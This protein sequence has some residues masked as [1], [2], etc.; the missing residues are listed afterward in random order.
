[1]S[2]PL[3]NSQRPTPC[4]LSVNFQWPVPARSHHFGRWVNHIDWRFV[5]ICS[6]KDPQTYMLRTKQMKRS[7]GIFTVVIT[8]I[9][10]GVGW[11]WFAQAFNKQPTKGHTS[12]ETAPSHSW[13]DSACLLP[14]P[15]YTLYIWKTLKPIPMNVE[16]TRETPINWKTITAITGEST[17]TMAWYEEVQASIS[18]ILAYAQ[19]LTGKLSTRLLMCQQ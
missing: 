7:L 6:P 1:M 9:M 18:T 5:Y 4:I 17:M 8:P 19:E 13:L 2:S 14:L 11:S 16:R 12:P 10:F 15:W 3:P